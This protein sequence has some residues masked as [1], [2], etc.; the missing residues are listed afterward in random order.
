MAIILSFILLGLTCSVSRAED[1]IS[2]LK[3]LVEIS[4]GSS[5]I[6]G[7]NAVQ[8]LFA[9]KLK[10]L[11]FTIEL[12]QDP[13]GKLGNLVVGTIKGKKPQYIT[14]LVHADTVFEKTSTLKDLK[15]SK[16]GAIARGP[17]VIDDKG[18]MVVLLTGLKEFL[19]KNLTR[20]YSIRVISNSGE[21]VGAP[22]FMDAFKRYSSEAILVLGFEPSREDGSIV[23]SRR[24]N[25]WY[26]I[27]VT[28]RE[29]HAG[30][31]HKEGINACWEMA[32]KIDRIAKL[33]NY[34]KDLTVNIGH[35]E[36]K[37]EKISLTSSAVRR[38]QRSIP[39]FRVLKIEKCFRNSLN[40]LY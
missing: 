36:W 19:A 4:S 17:G 9:D 34:A 14:L 24:G 32:K 10:A 23:T 30:R 15:S 12:I 29:A 2:L 5:D 25:R 40:E 20:N 3:N 7:V 26:E 22:G 21:E 13:Q 39:G 33:T 28:G 37:V 18:G 6:E 38:K 27:K 1:E 16:D 35:M 11:G 31:A 8:S